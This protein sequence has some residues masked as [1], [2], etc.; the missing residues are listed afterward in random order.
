MRNKVKKSVALALSAMMAFTAVP[1]APDADAAA[2]AKKITLSATKKTLTVG[3]KLTLKVKKV[4]PA[5]ANKKV[6]WKSRNF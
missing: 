4:K 1:A 5:K 6:T 2:K 3:A